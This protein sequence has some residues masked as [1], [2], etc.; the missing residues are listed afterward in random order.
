MPEVVVSQDNV[1][2]EVTRAH[3]PVRLRRSH[4]VIKKPDKFDL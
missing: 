2:Q 4:R 3:S 1:V